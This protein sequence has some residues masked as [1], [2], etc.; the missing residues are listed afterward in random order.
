MMEL[1][2]KA[3]GFTLP[4]TVSG[5]A[6]SLSEWKSEVGT[7]V[8]FI[9]NHCPYVHHINAPLVALAHRYQQKGIQ[10][11]AISSNN[12]ET[13]PQDAPELM[14]QVAAEEGYPFPYLYDQSQEVAKAYGAECTPDFFVFDKDLACVYRGRFDDSRP[15][16]DEATGSDLSQA[17]DAF[18]AGRPVSQEQHPS[19]GCNIKWK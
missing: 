11:L 13:H 18:L 17:L 9:C 8:V 7:V 5:Q 3:P 19:M 14:T 12:V 16:K 4:D 10:F 1:G 15:Q 2:A 6:V